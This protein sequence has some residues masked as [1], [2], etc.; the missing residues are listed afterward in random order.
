MRREVLFWAEEGSGIDCQAKSFRHRGL[1]FSG[2]F[3][4]DREGAPASVNGEH[5]GTKLLCTWKVAS[6][7]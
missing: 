4:T 6:P 1:A 3:W 5:L 2:P 7:N